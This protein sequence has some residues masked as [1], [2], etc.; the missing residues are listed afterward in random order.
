MVDQLHQNDIE[1]MV[2]V[3]YNHTG[4][5]GLWRERLWFESWDS[6]YEVNFDPKEVAGLYSYRG[7]DNAAYYALPPDGQTYWNNTGVGNQTR[8]NHVPME[9]LILDS[10]HFMVE[11]LHVD[12][13]R[14]DLAGILGEPDL[15]YNAW[16][17]PRETVLQDI[18]E[19][20]ILRARNVRLG[21]MERPLPRLVAFLPE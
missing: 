5:G 7:L 1:V 6:A 20:P 3:V 14:F 18:V 15:D 16:I 4:E 11:E 13:F 21:R 10:L 17:D 2:D 8:P 19:D 12:G 9:R